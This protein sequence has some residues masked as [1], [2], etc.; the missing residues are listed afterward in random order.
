MEQTDAA[1]RTGIAAI[2]P[3]SRL[4]ASR[5]RLADAI[6]RWIVSAGGIATIASIIGIFGFICLEVYPL[7]Q[8]PTATTT[9]SFRLDGAGPLFAPSTDEYQEAMAVITAQGAVRFLRLTGAGA[10]QELV[11]P[12]LAGRPVAAAARAGKDHVLLASADGQ[13]VGVR[14]A[15]DVQRQE[16]KRVLRPRVVAT[17]TW[18]LTS[19]GSTPRLL[20]ASVPEESAITAVFARASGPPTMLAVTASANLFGTG[21]PTTVYRDLAVAPGETPTALVVTGNGRRAFIGTAGGF[22]YYWDLTDK[23][24]PR[25]VDRVDA[26]GA[27][28]VPV[29]TM[30]LLIGE[31]SLVVGDQHGAVSVWFPVRDEGETGW[32]LQQVHPFTP[33]PA[34]VSAIAVSLRDK[35]FLTADVEGGVRLHHATTERTLL[36]L[37]RSA[38]PVSALVFSPRA[39]GGLSIGAGNTVTSWDIANPHPEVSLRALFGKIWY[40]GYETPAYVWQ[41]S[42]AADSAEPKL[43]LVPLIFG[44]MKGTV[45]ALLFAVPLAVLAAIYTSQFIHPDIRGLVKPTVEIM[46]AL[47]SVVLGFLAGLWLAPLIEGIVPAILAMLVVLPSMIF[48]AS[49][50]WGHLPVGLRSRM[51]QGTEVLLLIPLIVAGMALCL[52]ANGWVERICFGGDFRHWLSA[53]AGLRFDQRNC[54]VVGLAMGFAVI[55]IIFTISEDALANVP[56]RLVS[57]SLALGATRW[58]TALRVVVPTASPGIFSAI[59]IGFGRA[60][61]ET[62][63]VLMATGNT[64][65]LDWSIFTGMRTLSA[66]IAVEIPEAP[67]GGTLY[68]VLFLAA[69]LLFVATFVVN[70]F[71]DVVRTRLRRRYQRL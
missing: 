2:G 9:S 23:N 1:G 62:M 18:T 28:N 67:H 39:N 15:I 38:A 50:M 54:I 70:T 11:V 52:S 33:H 60:V 30:A 71:A 25:L 10:L 13:L 26:T 65:V 16:G 58:Q 7:W 4:S 69:L 48:V 57:G 42:G 17:G 47:P 8:A 61:G 6:A 66:N 29:T 20:S 45:Y 32:H 41:S 19:D 3:A 68:R 37:P 24:E 56:Q 34:A 31:Q 43:S 55:P 22:I 49:V 21:Q 12:G 51:R 53:V 14:I 63:I 59:M 46:A 64:P 40:E 35:R 36:E 5:R 27:R 44:T